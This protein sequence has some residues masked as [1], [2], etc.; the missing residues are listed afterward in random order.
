MR[1][2]ARAAAFVARLQPAL[3]EF[4]AELVQLTLREIVELDHDE[5]MSALLAASIA[6]NVASGTNAMVHQVEMATLEAPPAAL[7]YARRLGQR[8]IPLAALLRAYRIGQSLFL[9]LAAREITE[10]DVDD[11]AGLM[12]EIVQVLGAWID[13]VSEQVARAYDLERAQWAGSKASIRQQVVR[14]LLDGSSSDLL[15]AEAVLQYSVRDLNVAAQLWLEHGLD[16][17]DA[18]GVLDRSGGILRRA[19]G[20]SAS[21]ML[22]TDEQEARMWFGGANVHE[23]D[24]AALSAALREARLPVRVAVGPA[25]RGLS[26]FRSSAAA[27][28]RMTAWIRSGDATGDP[29]TTFGSMGPVTLLSDD[30][31]ELAALVERE[32]GRLAGADERLAGLRETLLVFLEENRSFRAAAERLLV[33]RNTVHYRV[34]QALELRGREIENDALGLQLALTICRWRPDLAR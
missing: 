29:V 17:H 8:E 22:P 24:P 32:L 28:T 25:R 30:P 6:E 2:T 4:S 15:R 11:G 16:S 23:P 1:S 9:D 7:E 3:D 33:H 18:V 14:E 26:G 12:I 5:R 10:S 19:L 27:V 21:L 31:E 20:A 34:Q 13:R